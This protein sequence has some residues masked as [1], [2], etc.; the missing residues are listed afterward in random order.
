[1]TQTSKVGIV[2]IGRNE[3]EVLRQ[4]LESALLEA[5]A[6]VY[7]DSGSTDDSLEIATDLEIEIIELD[8]TISFTA[9]RAYNAGVNH[10]LTS[11]P[12]LEFVQFLDGDAQLTT[13]WVKTAYQAMIQ[14]PKVAVVCGRRHEKF[15]EQSIFNLLA[16]MEWDTPIGEA[17]ECGP[18]SMMR[19]SLFQMVEGFNASLIAGE[20]PEICFRLRQVGG[21]ILRIDAD[22]SQH[23]INM[24]QLRQWWR[25]SRR[26]GYAY[27][28]EA[29]IHRQEAGYYRVRECLRIW[30]WAFGLPL[31][32]I[33]LMPI[34]ANFSL[35]FWLVGY[36]FTLSKTC[37][38]V[39]QKR[40]Y[41]SVKAMIYSVFCLLI[42]F[43]ELHGQIEFLFFKLLRHSRKI[44]EYKIPA[45]T[46][47]L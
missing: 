41:N 29:W 44:I 27:A 4:S 13:G 5:E 42:K 14:N 45:E 24:T 2:V 28:E 33:V 26:D 3:G 16:D 34:T 12:L 17:S 46:Q 9:A 7:V 43:P 15:P 36:L 37:V 40:Q 21:K 38:W 1:M 18:E 25:R 32:A 47:R 35:L 23:D 11:H 20:E 19:L 10:L 6:V 31:V 39:S 8:P 22:T 30:L